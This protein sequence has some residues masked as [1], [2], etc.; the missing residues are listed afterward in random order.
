MTSCTSNVNNLATAGT[1]ATATGIVNASLVKR[2]PLGTT[3][4]PCQVAEVST[5]LHATTTAVKIEPMPPK[6]E[7]GTRVLPCIPSF[8]RQNSIEIAQ[9]RPVVTLASLGGKK[10]KYREDAASLPRRRRRL[11]LSTRTLKRLTRVPV[12]RKPESGEKTFFFKAINLGNI[13]YESPSQG[14]E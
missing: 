4:V 14:H 11:I 2:E 6:S 5:S 3:T 13:I 12:R 8:Y 10:S 1:C 9:R 7:N